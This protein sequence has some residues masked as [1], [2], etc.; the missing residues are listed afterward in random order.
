MSIRSPISL[1]RAMCCVMSP[2][3]P[4]GVQSQQADPD[5]LQ[6]GHGLRQPGTRVAA[7]T[8]CLGAIFQ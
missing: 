7:R 6:R 1:A 8:Q 2:T 3:E 5:V 4:A